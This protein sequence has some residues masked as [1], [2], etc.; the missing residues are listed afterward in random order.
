MLQ[1]YLTLLEIEINSAVVTALLGIF[2]KIFI[3]K[4]L[5]ENGKVM[6]ARTYPR[7]CCLKKAKLD[8]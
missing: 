1:M 2:F 6:L 5:D 3:G 7:W 8:H 4:L